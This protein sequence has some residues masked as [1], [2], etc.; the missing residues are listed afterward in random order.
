MT[1][2]RTLW[3]KIQHYSWL[4]CALVCLFFALVF[5]AINDTDKLVEM[6]RTDIAQTQVQIQPEKVAATSHLGMLSQEVKP[7]DL[8]TRVVTASL[9]ESEFRGTKFVSENK[10]SWTIELFRASDE[11]IIKNYLKTRADRNQFYYFR[12]TGPDQQEQYMLVY[13][14]F[15]SESAA[16]SQLKQLELK[17]PASVRPHAVSFASLAPLVNDLGSDELG[18]VA[19]LH[20]INLKPAAL[21]RV[22]PQTFN[23]LANAPSSSTTSTTVTRRDAQGNVVDVRQSRSNAELPA[24]STK[25]SAIDQK[26]P[27]QTEREISD[28]FN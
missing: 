14:T 13:G 27:K 9:H 7:L 18:L 4:V 19:Q 12:L 21:P 26:A 5:W 10:K 11:E 15:G 25:A 2:H 3:Q 16:N 17:L 6:D 8:T 22:E 20:E 23:P 24:S 28:P 1:A